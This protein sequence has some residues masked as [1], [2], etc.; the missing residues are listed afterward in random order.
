MLT[1]GNLIRVSPCTFL[2]MR[3]EDRSIVVGLASG[4]DMIVKSFLERDSRTRIA[5]ER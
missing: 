4:E 2:A 1:N 5:S 3:F